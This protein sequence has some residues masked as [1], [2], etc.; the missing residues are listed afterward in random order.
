MNRLREIDLIKCDLD[1]N[2]KEIEKALIS[3]ANVVKIDDNLG[4]VNKLTIKKDKTLIIGEKSTV[5]LAIDSENVFEGKL[6]N[7]GT[8]INNGTLQI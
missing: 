1:K 7:N 3:L 8:L 5:S 4:V 6:L 2:F